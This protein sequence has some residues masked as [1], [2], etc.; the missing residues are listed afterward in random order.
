VE[1]AADIEQQGLIVIDGGDT[2]AASHP[3]KG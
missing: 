1:R 3:E 2:G